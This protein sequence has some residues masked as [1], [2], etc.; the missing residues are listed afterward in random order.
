[1]DRYNLIKNILSEGLNLPYKRA[2]SYLSGIASVLISKDWDARYEDAQQSRVKGYI[3]D[4]LVEVFS[5]VDV[6]VRVADNFEWSNGSN[7]FINFDDL[8]HYITD[9]G[10][11]S[12]AD[13]PD[14]FNDIDKLNRHIL[15]NYASS[16]GGDLSRGERYVGYKYNPDNEFDW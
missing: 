2:Q 12:F 7:G 14:L 5:D 4:I 16:A 9:I 3:K 15:Y 13:D 10:Y 8:D 6:I 11:R 1:M